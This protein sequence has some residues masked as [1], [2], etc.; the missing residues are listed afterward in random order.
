MGGTPLRICVAVPSHGGW[1]SGF[2]R[3]LV[4]MATHFAG[5]EYDGEKSLD[6]AVVKGSILPDV[7]HRC[8]MEAVKQDATHMLFLDSDMKFPPDLLARLLNHDQPIVGVNYP[9]KDGAGRTTAYADTDDFVGPL[10]TEEGSTGLVQVSHMG[11][12]ACLIDMRVFDALELP[13]FNFEP[14]EPHK[15]AFKGEDV[16]FFHKCSAA[17]I[18]AYCDQDLSKEI[19]HVGDFDYT[20]VFANSC[21]QEWQN[22]YDEAT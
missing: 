10:R 20:H 12:G 5:V 21:Y 4:R 11:L 6:V 1:Q 7:R 8:V 17:G 19:A 3:S 18:E 16:F 15:V 22:K 9:R 2:G 13:Y 14:I